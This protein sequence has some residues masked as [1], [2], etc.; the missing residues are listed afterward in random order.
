MIQSSPASG[1][2]PADEREPYCTPAQIIYRCLPN[3]QTIDSSPAAAALLRL[4][5][6]HDLSN[7]AEVLFSTWFP[8]PISCFTYHFPSP[9]DRAK[10]ILFIFFPISRFPVIPLFCFQRAQGLQVPDLCL[11]LQRTPFI[12][13]LQSRTPPWG[14]HSITQLLIGEVFHISRRHSWEWIINLVT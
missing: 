4:A 6:S 12:S 8:C 7:T 2:S 10:H 9:S 5:S 13:P 3:T 14:E 11:S 1:L